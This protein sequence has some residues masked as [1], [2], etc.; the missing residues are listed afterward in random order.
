MQRLYHNDTCEPNKKS[1]IPAIHGGVY[2]ISPLAVVSVWA[3]LKLKFITWYQLCV[4]IALWEMRTWRDAM[5]P[6]QRNL[7]RF[8]PRRIAQVLGKRRASPRLNQALVEI[9]RLNLAR[10]T[11]TE[12]SFT[13]SVDELH[14]DLRAEIERMLKSLGNKNT[15]R[16]IRMPRRLMRLIMKS[17]SRPL[18]AAVLFGMLLRMTPVKRYRWYKGCLTTTLLADVSGFNESCIKHERAALIREGCFERLVTPA[19]VRQQHGDWYALG[20]DLP[21]FSSPRTGAKRQPPAPTKEG[22]RQPPIMKPAPSFGIETN[23]FLPAQ[24][25]V[26]RSNSIPRKARV[27][28]W[29]HM[30]PEDLREPHRRM[31]LYK[32]ARQRGVIGNSPADRQTF[33]AAMARARRLGSINPCGMLRRIVET[34][35]YRR[36]ISDCDE[37]QARAWL[38]EDYPRGPS[39]TDAHRLLRK[40]AETQINDNQANHADHRGG[41]RSVTADQTEDFMVASYFT[42]KLRQ[43]GFAIHDAFNLIMTTEEGRTK[44]EGWTQARWDRAFTAVPSRLSQRLRVAN[45]GMPKSLLLQDRGRTELNPTWQDRPR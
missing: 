28:K 41:L 25:G 16:A 30:E 34:T 45:S 24:P 42:D 6:A 22:N 15:T 32:N 37:D 10:L 12:I 11:P 23:Q 27:P 38:V 3:A 5:E 33:Y 26:S 14:P 19:R 20:H 9:E 31:A 29:H 18:R 7:F 2:M 35:A 8:T 13:V 44:L 1:K 43:A 36:Y 4:W 17:R 39:A 40:I 21:L